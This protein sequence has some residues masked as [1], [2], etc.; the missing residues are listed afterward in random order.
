M[1]ER[2]AACPDREM[3]QMTTEQ[4]DV[5]LQNELRKKAPDENVVLPILE[6][7]RRREIDQQSDIT[8]EIAA[9]WN[10]YQAKVSQSNK[11]IRGKKKPWISKVATLAAVITLCILVFPFVVDAD[12][13]MDVFYRITDSVV[14]F[15][16]PGRKNVDSVGEYIF[17]TNN[18]GLQ[19]VY[20]AVVEMGVTIPVVPMWLPEGYVLTEMERAPVPGGSKL[21]ARLDSADATIVIQIKV[22]DN[23]TSTQYEKE[24]GIESYDIDQVEHFIMDNREYTSAIWINGNV[25][26]LIN[27]T[28]DKGMLE[29]ILDSIYWRK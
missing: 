24:N 1:R 7:L 19:Q 25:E 26:G 11:N 16:M 29:D 23:I 2:K 9:A 28:S 10:D 5:L 21:Y 13:M 12:G 18:P 20:D 22:F 6:E 15:F 8:D 17:E 3:E 14:E 4:L 27:I